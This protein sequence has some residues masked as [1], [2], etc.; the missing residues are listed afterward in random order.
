MSKG[1]DGKAIANWMKSAVKGIESGL[2]DYSLATPIKFDL[3][4]STEKV[5]GGGLKIVIATIGAS[6]SSQE[7]SRITFEIQNNDMAM[8]KAA[9]SA[10]DIWDK[11]SQ[12]TTRSEE[13]QIQAGKVAATVMDSV[14]K[15][16]AGSK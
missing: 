3:A 16:Y 1:P 11:A 10:L 7:V 5:G 2:G 8:V 13:S 4:V 9:K 15:A 12:I 14:V 6:K